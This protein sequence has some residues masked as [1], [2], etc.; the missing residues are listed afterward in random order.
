MM[1]ISSLIEVGFRLVSDRLAK[2]INVSLILVTRPFGIQNFQLFQ[3]LTV[4]SAAEN[5]S[6]LL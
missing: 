5:Y 6:T 2:K 4:S 1:Q 3:A